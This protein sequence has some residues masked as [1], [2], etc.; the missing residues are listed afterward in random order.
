MYILVEEPASAVF[1]PRLS[2]SVAVE[3]GGRLGELPARRPARRLVVAEVMERLDEA[4]GV[5]APLE[6]GT[7]V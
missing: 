5:V 4:S 6:E 7:R 1:P 2:G 3:E